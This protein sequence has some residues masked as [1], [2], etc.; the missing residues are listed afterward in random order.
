MVKIGISSMVLL[1][2]SSMAFGLG[3]NEAEPS[4]VGVTAI[5]KVIGDGQKV[6]AVALE[7]SEAIDGDIT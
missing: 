6:A 1:L 5:V 2:L 4:L 7:Y 3:S